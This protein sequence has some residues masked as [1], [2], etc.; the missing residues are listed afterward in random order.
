MLI[1]LTQCQSEERWVQVAVRF[2]SFSIVV[3]SWLSPLWNIF[4]IEANEIFLRF[5]WKNEEEGVEEEEGEEEAEAGGKTVDSNK[6]R[7]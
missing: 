5:E 6:H 1:V 7:S 2:F 4:V 3:N